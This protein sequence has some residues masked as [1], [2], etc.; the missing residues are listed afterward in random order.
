MKSSKGAWTKETLASL[1]IAW[2]PLGWMAIELMRDGYE[3]L[4]EADYLAFGDSVPES[5]R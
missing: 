2:P 3:P 4:E 1:G 5:G